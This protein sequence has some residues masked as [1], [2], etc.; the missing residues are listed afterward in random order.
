VQE[1]RLA[2]TSS[3]FTARTKRVNVR[4]MSSKMNL[5]DSVPYPSLAFLQTHPD[6]LAVMGTLH[7][8]NPAPVEHCRVLELGCG[9]GSNLIPMAYGLP[10][11]EFVGVDLAANP[12][13]FAQQRINRLELKNIRIEQ[14]DLME[15]RPDFG[16]FDYIIAHGVYAWVPEVVQKKIL[17][18]CGANLSAN[19][20]AF[21]SYNT[22]PAGHIRQ[23]LREMMQ[24]H[25]HRHSRTSQISGDRVNSCRDF[26]ESMLKV[27]DGRAP[28]KALFQGEL[29]LMFNRDERVVYHDDLAE[30]FS[31]V[32]FCDFAE[33]A[34]H[35]GLQF[36]SEAS[37]SDLQPPEL[38]AE[39]IATLRTLAGDDLIAQQQYLDFARYRRFRQTLLCHTEVGLRRNEASKRARSL[40]VA[41]PMRVSAELPDGSVEFTNSRG[42]GTLATNNP[43]IIA[44]LRRLELIWPRAERFEDLVSATR[45]LVPE[46]QQTETFEGFAQ[47]ML[48]LSGSQLADWRTYELPLAAGVSDKP[49]ASL[50]ARSMAQEGGTLTTLLHTHLNI[51][52]EQGR[53]F[54]Q[55]L[56]GSHDQQALTN[57]FAEAFPSDSPETILRHVNESLVNFYR[58]GL[59]EA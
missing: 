1:L 52:D 17:V 28:W 49:R 20:V 9:N 33:R 4:R 40:L 41:S 44:A 54:V 38:D 23:I 21:V 37:L 25:E 27:T 59:L 45:L 12:V 30:S 36:L 7:G 18:I 53:K 34:A 19:G 11:S 13:E 15:I 46:A 43:V 32:L 35:Y 10:G 48:K 3:W 50:L 6:R 14:L 29:K 2:R 8:M 56:D 22:N 58:M 47:A 31:P 42:Q 16:E 24:F 39:A 57:A 51:E 55:L 26:L 5:Y